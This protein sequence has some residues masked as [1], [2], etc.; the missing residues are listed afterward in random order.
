MTI[1]HC[2]NFTNKFQIE[3]GKQEYKYILGQN[4]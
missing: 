3:S 1:D 2:A 4:H